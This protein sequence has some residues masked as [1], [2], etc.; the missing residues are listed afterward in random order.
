MPSVVDEFV[1]NNKELIGRIN[2]EREP[3]LVVWA[4]DCFRR[5]LFLVSA[6]YFE[7]EI[8]NIL[9]TLVRTKAGSPLVTSFLE[10]SM[11][12]RYHDWFAWEGNNANR[13]FSMFGPQF[14]TQAEA[15][16]DAL[17]ELETA[18]RSFMEIGRT[19]NILVHE[20]LLANPVDKTADEVYELHN[21]ALPFL[22]Y[23]KR[24]LS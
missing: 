8:K 19:R 15:E 21:K 24:K 11:E 20:Q 6:N 12:R 17:P 23:L 7:T 1:V 22:E 4:N 10:K 14:K 16:V 3:T 18:I 9:L 2:V 13:F 5:F